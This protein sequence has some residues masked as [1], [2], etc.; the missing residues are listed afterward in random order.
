M[1]ENHRT[2]YFLMTMKDLY[3]LPLA[4]LK[5]KTRGVP[6]AKPAVLPGSWSERA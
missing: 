6:G 4:V 5:T 1:Y 2:N 3:L